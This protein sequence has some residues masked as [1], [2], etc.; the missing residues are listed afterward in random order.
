MRTACA[1][2]NMIKIKNAKQ[3]N[4]TIQRLCRPTLGASFARR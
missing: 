2:S 3:T 1:H 4:S